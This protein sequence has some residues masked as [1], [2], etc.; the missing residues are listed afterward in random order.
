MVKFV[1]SYFTGSI[2]FPVSTLSSCFC[3]SVYIQTF[4]AI[5]AM[6]SRTAQYKLYLTEKLVINRSF[7]HSCSCFLCLEFK[8][9]AIFFFIFL[10]REICFYQG[11]KLVT[12]IHHY[13]IFPYCLLLKNDFTR[14]HRFEPSGVIHCYLRSKTLNI[15]CPAKIWHDGVGGLTRDRAFVVSEG[16]FFPH[17]MVF[18]LEQNSYLQKVEKI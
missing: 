14:N 13:S 11:H 15:K 10:Y 2:E 8:H 6:H 7:S 18:C 1:L 12:T 16:F 9:C 5:A 4:I 17:R 3:V